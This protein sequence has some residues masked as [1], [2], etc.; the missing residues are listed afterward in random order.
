MS[1]TVV[2]KLLFGPIYPA[3]IGRWDPRRLL[4]FGME[5][6]VINWMPKDVRII[7]IKATPRE[8]SLFVKCEVNTRLYPQDSTL[9]EAV[10]NG[11]A[12]RPTQTWFHKVLRMPP[13]SVHNVL[14]DPFLE[15]VTTNWT[16]S[17]LRVTLFARH[18]HT[19]E[20]TLTHSHQH[21]ANAAEHTET[22]VVGV[23]DDKLVKDRRRNALWMAQQPHTDVADESA[24]DAEHAHAIVTE[25]SNGDMTVA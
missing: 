18:R 17:K 23:S 25:V 13:I 9:L 7:Y 3:S 19:C 6:K 11:I 16:S 1:T 2:R 14:G 5:A 22:A 4:S 21:L 12:K 20:P 24:V 10:K 8:G 15:D